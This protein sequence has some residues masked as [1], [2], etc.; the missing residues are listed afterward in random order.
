MYKIFLFTFFI[1][2]IVIGYNIIIVPG[3][4]GSVLYNL[5]NKKIWPPDISINLKELN[6]NFDK[7]NDPNIETNI[8]IGNILD[9]KIDN[10]TTFI[11]TKNIYYSNLIKS[12]QNDKHNLYS[13][14]YDFRYILFKNYQQILYKKFKNFIE[15]KFNNDEK[16]IIVCHS[17]GG[18]VLHHFLTTFV[19]EIWYKK[20]I[21]K[22]Y[23]VNV[24][25]GGS[26]L[27]LYTI[28]DSIEKKNEKES[29]SKNNQIVSVLNKKIKDLYLFSCFY[30]TLPISNEP[31]LR[32]NDI[33]YN[34]RNMKDIFPYNAKINKMYELF[35][36]EHTLNRLN[37][38]NIETNIIY[39]IGKNTTSFLDYESGLSLSSDGDGLVTKNSMIIPKLWKTNPNLISVEN[40]EHSNINN[41]LPFIRMISENKDKL[42][43]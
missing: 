15:E 13:F 22:I 39:C 41:H 8:N 21:S 24:P 11:L 7:N 27:S 43:L 31:I 3:M 12:L 33:W 36:N 30:M 20:F 38:I 42:I 19:D 18:L 10:P 23:F 5:K 26:S 4:G 25:F 2:K 17:L 9:I 32:K 14:S 1:I 28:M 16:L 29:L 34:T 6:M 37:G 40:M 35:E